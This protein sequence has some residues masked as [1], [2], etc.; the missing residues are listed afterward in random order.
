MLNNLRTLFLDEC[1]LRD[2]F[3][4]LC[5]LLRRSPN[6]EKLSV[7]CCKLPEGSVGGKGKARKTH[8]WSRNLVRF[9]CH[10]LKSTEIIYEKG[11]KIQE[12]VY[13]LLDISE[14]APMDTVTLTK[15]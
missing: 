2:N 1:D 6:L 5:H 7:R 12:L 3:R 14:C 11:D 9:Q 13:L 4:I 8:L 15:V 10:K